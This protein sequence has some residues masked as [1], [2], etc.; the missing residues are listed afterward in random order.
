MI[1]LDTQLVDIMK[2]LLSNSSVKHLAVGKNFSRI[3]YSN[4]IVIIIV[5]MMCI[6]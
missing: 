4:H 5:T 3:K 1:G 2:S 6:N